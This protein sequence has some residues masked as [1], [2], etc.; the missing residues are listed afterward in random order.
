MQANDQPQ[1]IEYL[2]TFK[3]QNPEMIEIVFEGPKKTF[4]GVELKGRVNAHG[5]FKDFEE[6][7]IRRL[8]FGP[9]ASRDLPPRVHVDY[10]RPKKT[11]AVSSIKSVCDEVYADIFPNRPPVASNRP[12]YRHNVHQQASD[13]Q[14]QTVR[15]Q[16]PAGLG[17]YTQNSTVGPMRIAPAQRQVGIRLPVKTKLRIVSTGSSATNTKKAPPG[18]HQKNVREFSTAPRKDFAP[19]PVFHGQI[20]VDQQC[21]MVPIQLSSTVGPI[22]NAPRPQTIPTVPK[23]RI[24]EGESFERKVK[25]SPPVAHHKNVMI[26]HPSR[27]Q[28]LQ[29]PATP[30]MPSAPTPAVNF[31]VTLDKQG[32]LSPPIVVFPPKVT[33]EQQGSRRIFHLPYN[34]PVKVERSI[35]DELMDPN[36]KP[37]VNDTQCMSAPAAEIQVVMKDPKNKKTESKK[38]K[39]KKVVEEELEKGAIAALEYEDPVEQLKFEKYVKS[40]EKKHGDNFL[41]MLL[42]CQIPGLRLG[43]G[44][45]IARRED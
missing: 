44:G 7:T 37:E 11:K 17:T 18:E 15:T 33:V 34:G 23:F 4:P 13:Q 3:A 9:G 42:W 24:V 28:W 38:E 22:R 5:G 2:D 21:Q 12:Q 39:K 32:E 30:V 27:I 20:T 19:D 35:Y 40:M 29:N 10:Q 26:P 8:Q 41:G 36:F 1:E 45:Q 25:K 6:P 16:F 14:R 31:Q 43:C